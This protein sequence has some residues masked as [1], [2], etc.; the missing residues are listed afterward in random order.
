MVQSRRMRGGAVVLVAACVAI[1]G[2]GAMMHGSTT[3]VAVASRPTGAHAWVDGRYVGVTPIRVMLPSRE[4]HELVV[5]AEGYQERRVRLEPRV[6][7][8][9]I[10][11]DA[12]M[13]FPWSM[14]IDWV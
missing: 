13:G 11:L 8:G 6:T 10:V 12:M 9:Y 7:D 1:S 3:Q 2:C 5:R 4:P 14:L